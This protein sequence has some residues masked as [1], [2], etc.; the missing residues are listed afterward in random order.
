MFLS[1]IT[2][3][4]PGNACPVKVT[5]V[6]SAG[7]LLSSV[8]ADGVTVG[9]TIEVVTENV[10]VLEVPPPGAGVFTVTA[11]V[12]SVVSIALGMVVVIVDGNK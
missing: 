8:P 1:T 2:T 5:V 3:E 11:I 10:R 6:G 9:V 4:A 7:A 12:C